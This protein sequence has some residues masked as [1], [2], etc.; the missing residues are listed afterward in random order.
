MRCSCTQTSCKGWCKSVSSVYYQNQG[1][2]EV[3]ISS[4]SRLRKFKQCVEKEKI[5]CKKG[6]VL[7]DKTKWNSTLL[8]LEAA[9]KFEKAFARLEREDTEFYTK[10]CSSTST[11]TVDRE[12]SALDIEEASCSDSEADEEASA[13]GKKTS[14]SGK[15]RSP[16][17][18]PDAEDWSC[19]RNFVEF[20]DVVLDAIVKFSAP[21][22]VTSDSFLSNLCDIHELR[23]EVNDKDPSL[24]KATIMFNKY[25]KVLRKICR[26]ASFL[27][28]CCTA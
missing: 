1:S 22:Y 4:P 3:C 8:M 7:D 24:N 14:S 17:R 19:A 26:H 9:E 11:S 18:A 25:Y 21:T 6:L 10:F 13:L 28:Y 15:G 20:L 23:M 2:G 16:L 12:A 27:V 5:A